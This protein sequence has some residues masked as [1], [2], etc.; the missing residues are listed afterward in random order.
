[1]FSVIA[2]FQP[3]LLGFEV[4]KVCECRYFGFDS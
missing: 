2:F 1:M 3:S 4:S